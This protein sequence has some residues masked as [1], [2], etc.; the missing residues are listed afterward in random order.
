M[1]I[2]RENLDAVL[3]AI[4]EAKVDA[5]VGFLSSIAATLRSG[6]VEETPKPK[7]K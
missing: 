3:N 1:E 7:K 6:I 2:K 5:T 4:N